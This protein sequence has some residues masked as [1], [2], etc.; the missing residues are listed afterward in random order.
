MISSNKNAPPAEHNEKLWNPAYILMLVLGLFTSAASQMV[1]PNLPEYIID[2][3][4]SLTLSSTITSLMSL[5][6][7]VLRPVSGAANDI[8]SR[9]NLMLFSTGLTAACLVGYSIAPTLPIIVAI[10]I[11]HGV[12]FSV[13]GV[14]NMAFATSFIPKSRLGEGLGYLALSNMISQM[15]GPSIGIFLS[16]TLGTQYMFWAA[17]IIT[18]C[19]MFIVLRVP[20]KYEKSEI[21]GKARLK[22][23]KLSNLIA[24]ELLFYAFLIG[25]FSCGNALVSTFL[26]LMADERGVAN[27]GLYFTVNSLFMVFVRPMAGKLTDRKGLAFILIPAYIIE[28]IA[29]AFIGSLLASVWPVK[30]GTLYTSISNGTIRTIAQGFV[31]IL[32]F[33]LIY[34]ASE[35]ITIARRVL[36]DCIVA[37]H[38]SEI[39]EKSIGKLLKMPV[40]YYSG[41]LSGEKTAQL[42]QGVAGLSQ[43]IKILC[44]DIFATI[45]TAV[46]TLIQVMLN[47][48]V[49]MAVIILTYLAVTLL[50]GIST[51][52]IKQHSIIDV[53]CGWALSAGIAAAGD[54][55]IWPGL[56]AVRK[57][58]GFLE[59]AKTAGSGRRAAGDQI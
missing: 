32:M 39:R 16:D 28:A 33:G 47:A 5:V 13:Q 38:E 15:L 45:L 35:C 58:D 44:N 9:K 12:A 48:P 36:L 27:I 8:L 59:A 6:A 10:R 17:A 37:T 29:M 57:R 11:L 19:S 46:C 41:C 42:N 23:I 22:Q 43:L 20:Y 18:L 2:M 34:L 56:V 53:V 7:M 24:K 21:S 50:I 1:T 25:M 31:G 14:S 52:F 40:S 4:A 54:R 30:L 51:M 3:G 55:L 26:K 49:I